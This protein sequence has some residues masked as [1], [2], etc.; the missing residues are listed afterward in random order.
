MLVGYIEGIWHRGMFGSWFVL[1]IALV[2]TA[3]QTLISQGSFPSDGSLLNI[4]GDALIFASK[5]CPEALRC[6]LFFLLFLQM[7]LFWR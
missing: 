3:G 1:V 4:T 5:S 7:A 2:L 6:F